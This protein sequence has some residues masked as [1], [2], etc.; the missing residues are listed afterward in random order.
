MVQTG[1]LYIRMTEKK[2]PFVEG[3][4][5]VPGAEEESGKHA[6]P[7]KIPA[8]GEHE[9]SV[10]VRVCLRVCV[11]VCVCL[12]TVTISERLASKC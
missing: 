12:Q 4:G 1:L 5:T 7:Q 11:C 9:N 8:D 6:K 3:V 10:C 2:E